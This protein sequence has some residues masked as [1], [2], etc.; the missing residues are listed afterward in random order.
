MASL[1]KK[2]SDDLQHCL[3]EH[4]KW[5]DGLGGRYADLREADLIGADLRKANLSRADLSRAYLRSADLTGADLTRADLREADLSRARMSGVDLR[6]ADLSEADL[7]G[8]DLTRADLRGADLSEVDLGW[9]DLTGADL[10]WAN[11]TGADLR[12][13]KLTDADLTHTCLDSRILDWQRA[14]MAACPADAEGYRIVYRS[15]RSLYAGSTIYEPGK[16]YEA[17]YLSFS[18]E[19]PCHPGIYV[20]TLEQIKSV[21][22]DYQG[23]KPRVVRGRIKDGDWVIC[24]KGA[25]TARF[26]CLEV[27]EDMQ[28]QR[29]R[30]ET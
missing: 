28:S 7:T 14:F 19:S 13:A 27:V 5:L 16:L 11:L 29:R 1:I 10:R 18:V 4:R 15:E 22:D 30:S 24:E 12:Q 6:W 25:R 8:A 9:A 20:G 3:E 23:R 17:P 2:P 26:E 21:V